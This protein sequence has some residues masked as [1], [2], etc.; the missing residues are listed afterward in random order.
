MKITNEKLRKQLESGM[1]LELGQLNLLKTRT[2]SPLT[3]EN[4]IRWKSNPQWEMQE[5]IDKL[6][7]ELKG[8]L[9]HL[10]PAAEAEI[11]QEYDDEYFDRIAGCFLDA[12]KGLRAEDVEMKD[13]VLYYTEAYR[14]ARLAVAA[15]E[16]S[17][18]E[19]KLF[20]A[21][22]EARQAVQ[23][24][25]SVLGGG[26]WSGELEHL[27]LSNTDTAEIVYNY[28]KQQRIRKSLNN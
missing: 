28:I 2:R 23:K 27:L 9:R 1:N 18:E 16:L 14:Q 15:M 10:R 4:L 8:H 3:I 21:L 25:K 7:K 20:N 24:L 12:P 22:S 17:E 19:T 11:R 13:G 5:Q 6:E 26:L